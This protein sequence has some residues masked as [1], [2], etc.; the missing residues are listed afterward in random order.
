MADGNLETVEKRI[1]LLE[2]L[3][4]GT[5]EK[6]ALYPKDSK[7]KDQCI[8]SLLNAHAEV[9]KATVGKKAIPK[10]Y[11]RLTELRKY[12]DPGYTDEMTLSNEAIT[13][14]ILA[15]EDFL[16]QQANRLEQMEGLKEILDSAH[17]KGMP[18]HSS[19]LQ[20][21]SK[22]QI[23]QQDQTGL[24]TDDVRGLLENYNTIVSLVSKQ[25][26]QWDQM[27]TKVEKAKQK[28]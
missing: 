25:L 11:N 14:I 3:V 10:V 19:K 21:L 6:D 16:N 28:S 24:F 1:S 8:H 15:E 4:F 5:S 20:E 7:S 23:D 2:N 17:I 26:I 22:I 18:S 9:K 13:D 27:V 12:L